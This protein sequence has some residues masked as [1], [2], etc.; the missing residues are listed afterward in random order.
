VEYENE[1]VGV[2]QYF[3]TSGFTNILPHGKKRMS[4]T[5]AVRIKYEYCCVI[6]MYV[7]E[8]KKTVRVLFD[9]S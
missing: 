9:V 7:I 2:L 3:E 4:A 1:K 5:A 8:K 6:S